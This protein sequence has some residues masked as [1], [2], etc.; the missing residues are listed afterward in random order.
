MAGETKKG[1]PAGKPRSQAKSPMEL[2]I[3]RRTLPRK[4]EGQPKI[5]K[6]SKR[7]D[8]PSKGGKKGKVLK[9]ALNLAVGKV[10]RGKEKEFETKDD[11][12]QE[13]ELKSSAETVE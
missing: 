4:K 6:G 5:P 3:P 1:G 13:R 12:T 11:E 9:N 7:K 2:P 8:P 10:A